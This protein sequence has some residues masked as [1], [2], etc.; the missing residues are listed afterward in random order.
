MTTQS[1][2]LGRADLVEP[3]PAALAALTLSDVLGYL[4]GCLTV[5]SWLIPQVLRD[6]MQQLRDRFPAAFHRGAFKV[7]AGCVGAAFTPG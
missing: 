5:T 7:Q 3:A 1:A 6:V 2:G 4:P